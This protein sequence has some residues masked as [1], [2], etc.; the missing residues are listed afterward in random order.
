ML[1]MFYSGIFDY[2][3]LYKFIIIV[4]KSYGKRYKTMLDNKLDNIFC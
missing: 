1:T 4:Y 3:F 2:S